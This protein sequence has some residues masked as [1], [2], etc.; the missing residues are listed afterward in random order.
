MM[1]GLVSDCGL[2]EKSASSAQLFKSLKKR[3]AL[4]KQKGPILK[5]VL[6][7]M[8]EALNAD[9]ADEH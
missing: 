9:A 6:P 3:V 1:R 8:N 4:L 7:P 5:P 2:F